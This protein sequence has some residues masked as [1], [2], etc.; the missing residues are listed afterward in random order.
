MAAL[1]EPTGNSVEHEK[2][3]SIKSAIE[4]AKSSFEQA[5]MEGALASVFQ[6]LALNSGE[7]V[8]ASTLMRLRAE[9]SQAE[10]SMESPMDRALR[11]SAELLHDDSTI[12]GERGESEILRDAFEDGSSF[13]CTACGGLVACDRVDAH[14]RFWCSEAPDNELDDDDE[15]G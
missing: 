7:E 4:K 1:D 10:A 11:I 15:D 6:A 14:R 5:D 9:L 13:V 8:A 3:A 12:L 2:N